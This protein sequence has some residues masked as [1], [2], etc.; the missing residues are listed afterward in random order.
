ME[1]ASQL[2]NLIH[3]LENEVFDKGMDK[4]MERLGDVVLDAK[5]K[6]KWTSFH[7]KPRTKRKRPDG[8]DDN[9]DSNPNSSVAGASTGGTDGAE[10]R[11]K[12]YEAI[13]D[14][15]LDDNGNIETEAIF[16]VRRPLH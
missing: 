16:K 3:T 9:R 13:P 5:R 6:H 15:T 12:G 11:E 8:G 4:E 10:L 1:F 2:Y 14:F 7:T